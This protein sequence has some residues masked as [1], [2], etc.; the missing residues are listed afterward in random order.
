MAKHIGNKTECAL[1][2]YVDKIG[3]SYSKI[4]STYPCERFLKVFPFSSERKM[5]ATVMRLSGGEVRVHVKGAPEIVLRNCVNYLGPDGEIKPLDRDQIEDVM[6][7]I[8]ETMGSEGLRTICVAT[9]DLGSDESKF[10][11]NDESSVCGELTCLALIGIEDPV[12][13]EVPEAIRQCQE[14]GVVVRMITGDNVSTARS[15]ALKCGILKPDD[16]FLILES[17]DFNARVLDPWGNFIQEKF[18]EVFY[19]FFL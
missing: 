7:N 19:P 18:D 1:I 6:S 8:V 14:A 10:D 12:R 2:E 5:M 13:T 3:G 11:W 15:I 17:K 4:R 16:N 9:R